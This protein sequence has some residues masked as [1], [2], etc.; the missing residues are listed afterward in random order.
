MPSLG[1][2]LQVRAAQARR[3]YNQ[4]LRSDPT[5]RGAIVV[6]VRIGGDGRVCEMRVLA[7]D[8]PQSMT[9]CALSYF[10]VSDADPYTPP[11]GGCVDATV[12]I[13]FVPQ[14]RD[15]GVRAAD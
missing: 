3:C 2:I 14:A 1:R 8:M 6:L 12:P 5:L 13:K 4:A 7:S 11:I 9:A 15:A 10:A